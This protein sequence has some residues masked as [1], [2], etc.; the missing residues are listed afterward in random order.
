MRKQ[1]K[2]QYKLNEHLRRSGAPTWY[3]HFGPKKFLLADLVLGLAVMCNYRLSYRRASSF[4]DEYY[5]LSMHWTTLQKAARRLPLKLWQAVLAS[6]APEE[7]YQAA[8]DATGFSPNN[9]SY[10][11]LHRIDGK[12]PKSSVKT[13]I[14]VDVDTRKV[15]SVRVRMKPRHDSRDVAG[16]IRHAKAKPWQIVMDKGYDNDKLHAF[17]DEKNIWSIA[18]TK[19]NCQTGRFR[20][21]LR[22]AFPEGEYRYRNI[23]ESVYRSVK[24]LFGGSVR[25]QQARTVRAELFMKFIMHNLKSA[26]HALFLQTP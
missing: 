26:L 1:T 18:P 14:L 21:G 3:H 23:V 25:S 22:D 10:H 19:K 4:L 12:I 16:L 8:V 20:L 13:S 11:Y 6:T 7:S 17:L 2:L 9:P 15:M 24:T 5:G